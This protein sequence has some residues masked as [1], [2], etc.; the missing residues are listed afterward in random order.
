MMVSQLEEQ[1]DRGPQN[2]QKPS[3][4][5]IH[6]NQPTRRPYPDGVGLQPSQ[7]SPQRS[8][9]FYPVCASIHGHAVSTT[10]VEHAQYGSTQMDVVVRPH[11][12]QSP[13]SAR[14]R[15][16]ERVIA[17]CVLIAHAD[18]SER[19]RVKE[20]MRA[21]PAFADVSTQNVIEEFLRNEQD[22]ARAP[23]GARHQVF[24]AAT[25]LR[26]DPANAELLLCA[27]KNV[28]EADGVYHPA[29]YQV[30]H[31]IGRAVSAV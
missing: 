17:A 12:V 26:G 13:M 19:Y 14:D 21:L 22:F 3:G 24:E 1:I 18:G 16:M 31:E 10:A 9:R 8:D 23:S 4:S 28:F 30:L 7:A 11:L 15:L 27:C 29:E 25:A 5:E 20:I 2:S 6:L